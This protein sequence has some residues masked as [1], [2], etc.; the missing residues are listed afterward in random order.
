VLADT[1]LRLPDFRASERTFSLVTQVAGRAGRYTPDGRVLVQTFRPQADA[2]TFAARH[3]IEG[4]FER[5]L[6]VRE[7][8][9]FPPFTRLIR[10]VFRSK[11]A[12]AADGAASDFSALA[13]SGLP[14]G[15]ELLGPAE[16]PIAVIAGNS[17]RH[18]ILRGGDFGSLHAA[19]KRVAEAFEPPRGVYMEVDLDPVSLL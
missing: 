10:F 6:A 15:V 9:G 16:C 18:A 5:E 14:A 8:T 3:D 12:E 2:V 19:A 13:L 11:S 7:M 4:F 1:S 17:R